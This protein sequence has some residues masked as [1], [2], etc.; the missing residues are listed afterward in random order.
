MGCLRQILGLSRLDR[1]RNEEIRQRCAN[2]ELLQTV[3]RRLRLRWLGHVGR[4]RPERVPLQL[5][6]GDREGGQRPRGRA[7]T[8]CA[9]VVHTDL[10][11]ALDS[12]CSH[13][14]FELC[15]ERDT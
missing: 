6:F 11:A 14:W 12:V 9:D 8:R 7:C 1:V 5:L 10:I 13:R 4:M 15:Q 2:G 3:L